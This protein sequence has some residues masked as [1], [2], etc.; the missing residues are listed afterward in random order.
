MENT[1]SR[2]QRILIVDDDRFVRM[3]VQLGLQKAGYDT[4]TAGNGEE[5]IEMLD[6]NGIDLII[7]DLMMPVM[8]GLTFLGWLRA[9]KHAS[10]PALVLSS[11]KRSSVAEEVENSG[12][13]EFISKPISLPDLRECVARLLSGSKQFA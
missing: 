11:T 9:G 10:L 3:A 5:A 8:D 2:N 13:T 6:N 12:A 7:V 1:E 4:V